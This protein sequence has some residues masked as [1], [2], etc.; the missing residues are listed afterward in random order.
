MKPRV[1][2]FRMDVF[3]MKTLDGSPRFPTSCQL[4]FRLMT[5]LCSNE[6][7]RLFHIEEIPVDIPL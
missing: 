7:K 6:R 4:M 5:I 3:K 1:G 2:K